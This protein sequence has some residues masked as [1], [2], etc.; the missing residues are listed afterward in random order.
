[1]K[2]WGVCWESHGEV[3]DSRVW[4]TSRC[5]CRHVWTFQIIRIMIVKQRSLTINIFLK[6]QRKK[7]TLINSRLLCMLKHMSRSV[8][9]GRQRSSLEKFKKIIYENWVI[10]VLSQS[11]GWRLVFLI[12]PAHWIVIWKTMKFD[13]PPPCSKLQTHQDYKWTAQNHKSLE[14]KSFSSGTKT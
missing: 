8:F 14:E 2:V 3:G 11:M 9:Y 13:I 10:K 6:T 1:M 12:V 4:M 7:E 5:I